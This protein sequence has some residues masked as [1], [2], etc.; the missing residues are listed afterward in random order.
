MRTH[1]SIPFGQT[2]ARIDHEHVGGREY[3]RSWDEDDP[4]DYGDPPGTPVAP[5]WSVREQR[6]VR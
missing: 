2:N 6:F 1:E 4:M 5:G 3:P